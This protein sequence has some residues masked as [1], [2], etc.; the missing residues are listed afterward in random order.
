M[1]CLILRGS[2]IV[3]ALFF[4]GIFILNAFCLDSG[5]ESALQVELGYLELNILDKDNTI[6]V[7]DK[8]SLDVYVRT[9]D[10]QL[11]SYSTFPAV[12][13]SDFDTIKTIRLPGA[14]N[15]VYPEIVI[16]SDSSGFSAHEKIDLL[17]D[18]FD[19]RESLRHKFSWMPCPSVH[20]QN[21]L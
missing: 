10:E 11:L 12:A 13:P 9:E 2:K 14:Q 16:R 8:I 1:D 18:I 20:R 17:P 5:L 19:A 6:R 4:V 7:G 21:N 15:E 3:R